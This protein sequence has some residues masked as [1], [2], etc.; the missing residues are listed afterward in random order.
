MR[1]VLS[2][3]VAHCGTV[4]RREL[5]GAEDGPGL[6]DAL[7]RVLVVRSAGGVGAVG[8]LRDL[9]SSA[10][11]GP[12][13]TLPYRGRADLVASFL[14]SV[15]T[16]RVAVEAVATEATR[17]LMGTSLASRLWV[18]CRVSLHLA[19]EGEDGKGCTEAGSELLR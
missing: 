2:R 4:V 11:V 15:W 17:V 9:V 14:L 6:A 19:K 8:Q 13:I 5:E 18:P 16:P 1:A 3:E 12:D 10:W 7:L